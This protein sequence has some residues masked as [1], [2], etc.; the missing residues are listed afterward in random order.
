MECIHTLAEGAS[1]DVSSATRNLDSVEASDHRE[2]DPAQIDVDPLDANTDL[3]AD[4]VALLRALAVEDL[5][6]LVVLV[7][8][9][10][11]PLA[12]EEPFDERIGNPHE[13]AGLVH[14]GDLAFEFV[15]DLLQ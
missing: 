4:L 8:I 5:L 1:E 2:I 11:H 15:A 9:V 6:L 14:A 7:E 10:G 13:E 12:R 3:V